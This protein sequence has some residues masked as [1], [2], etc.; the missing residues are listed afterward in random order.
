M[1]LLLNAGDGTEVKV[2]SR[3]GGPSNQFSLL[4]LSLTV[5]RVFAAAARPGRPQPPRAC[6]RPL[7]V[8]AALPPASSL[9]TQH[10]SGRNLDCRCAHGGLEGRP[11]AGS[12]TWCTTR[13]SPWR[14]PGLG[15]SAAALETGCEGTSRP[16]RALG[17]AL[18]AT[19]EGYASG[20]PSPFSPY[21]HSDDRGSGDAGLGA[22]VPSRQSP[23][24]TRG[25][26]LQ[27]S[28]G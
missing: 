27:Q 26:R 17:R 15:M 22:R 24:G 11:A 20:H 9:L 19:V 8:Q 28:A 1:P 21:R 25:G 6:M 23:S 13:Q 16:L 7:C 3:M 2:K 12:L 10:C 18:R 5:G 4:V 14:A